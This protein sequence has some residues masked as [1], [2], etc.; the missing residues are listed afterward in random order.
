MTH[1][2][3]KIGFITIFDNINFGTYLQAYATAFVLDKLGHTPELI[4][5]HRPNSSLKKQLLGILTNKKRSLVNRFIYVM[6][7]VIL[8][9][10]VKIRFRRFV[11]QHFR[12]TKKFKCIKELEQ[13]KFD[14]DVYIAG[15]DQI[16]NSKYN[17]VVDRA[18]FL[19]FTTGKK[20]SYASSIGSEK[21]PVKESSEIRKL[22]ESFDFISVREKASIQ[23]IRDIGITQPISHV[24]DPT[25]LMNK[26]EWDYA[27]SYCRPKNIEEKFL[28]VYSV[29]AS[30]NHIVAEQAQKISAELG[31]KIYVI[32]ATEGY[33]VRNIGADRV[34][35]FGHPALLTQLFSKASFAIVSSF[36]GTAFALNFNI[37]FLTVA[38]DN[39]NIRITSLLSMFQITD[40]IVT[41]Q[42][43]SSSRPNPINFNLINQILEQQR[44]LSLTF[45]ENAIK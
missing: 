8:I 17:E 12:V 15:S 40:R 39:F 1:S 31:L 20:I 38:P 19:D 3:K 5:Y 16:W 2:K 22:L 27:T 37:P 41:D 18:Y 7:S 21:V 44:L 10:Y 29:E 36:H 30:R 23:A 28:L 33:K 14:Y 24:L 26:T 13:K 35:S 11:S 4:N 32:T 9:P 6:G 43:I 34:Y 42:V 45:L 25:L